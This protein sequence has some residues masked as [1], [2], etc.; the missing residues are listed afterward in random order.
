MQLTSGGLRRR[1]F[2][3][4]L[5]LLLLLLTMAAAR[6]M[7]RAAF[8][9]VRSDRISDAHHN[10]WVFYC[11]LRHKSQ[12][13]LRRP[14]QFAYVSLAATALADRSFEATHRRRVCSHKT[15]C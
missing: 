10:F 14:L 8:V 7:R 2:E 9:Y 1:H 6:P 15:C 11:R 4:L 3:L 12:L 5:L 13:P